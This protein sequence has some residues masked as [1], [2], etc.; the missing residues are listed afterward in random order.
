MDD[1]KDLID[2]LCTLAGM[3]FEDASAEAILTSPHKTQDQDRIVRIRTAGL[4]AQK[5]ADAALIVLQRAG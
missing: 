2:Q 1:G 4:E 5:L 3:I